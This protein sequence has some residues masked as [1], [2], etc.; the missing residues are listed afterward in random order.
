[1]LSDAGTLGVGCT[2]SLLVAPHEITSISKRD[3]HL[4]DKQTYEQHANGS[5]HALTEN[6]T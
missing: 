5:Q 6:V 2:Y 4:F 3:S 1:M